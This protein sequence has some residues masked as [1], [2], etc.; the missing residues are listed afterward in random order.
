MVPGPRAES[1]VHASRPGPELL[2]IGPRAG[3]DPPRGLRGA[4][5]RPRQPP[6][7]PRLLA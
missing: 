6:L 2:L 7:H 1:R 3:P 5:G 4:G